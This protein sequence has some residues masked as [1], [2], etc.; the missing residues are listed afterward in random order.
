QEFYFGTM[1]RISSAAT[2]TFDPQ[3]GHWINRTRIGV[4]AS[5]SSSQ[6]CPSGQSTLV[7]L[8]RL[9]PTTLTTSLRP[10][11]YLKFKL[12]S[13]APFGSTATRVLLE[14]RIATR[15]TAKGGNRMYRTTSIPGPTMR[16]RVS[17]IRRR[18]RLHP[19]AP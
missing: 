7:L 16:L 8:N 14:D 12:S 3:I 2:T 6:E 13:C 9:S 15:P 11:R 4:S 5:T 19:D 1:P 17:L 18:S 10:W